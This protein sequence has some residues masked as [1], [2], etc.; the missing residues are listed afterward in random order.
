MIAHGIRAIVV[1]TI[2]SQFE[3]I[4]ISPDD[5]D[6]IVFSHAH[7]DHVGNARLFRNAKWI[8]QESEYE[9]MYGT[10]PEAFAY[11]PDLYSTLRHN[12]IEIVQGDCDIFDDGAVRL[13]YT[14]G[15]TLGHCSLLVRLP[16]TG[17]VVLSGDVAHD[18]CNLKQRRVPAINADQAA[19]LASMQR[20]EDIVRDE[21]A[22]LWVN[23]DATQ[24]GT[25]PHAPAWIV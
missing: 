10:N 1:R 19:S 11:I 14:P 24:S 20:I 21:G 12:E 17:P 3:A 8:V 13:I 15:H 4:G 25:L 18:Y 2:A 7:Y 16:R 22:K 9:A 23:H 6:I 5:V